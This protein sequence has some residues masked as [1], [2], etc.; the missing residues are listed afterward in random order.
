MQLV[1]AYLQSF[2]ASDGSDT[3][4]KYDCTGSGAAALLNG[5]L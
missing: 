1:L 5:S 3:A 2:L 4:I